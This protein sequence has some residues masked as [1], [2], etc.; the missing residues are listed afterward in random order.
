METDLPWPSWPCQA[1]Q[2]VLRYSTPGGGGGGGGGGGSFSEKLHIKSSADHF[3]NAVNMSAVLNRIMQSSIE[4]EATQ[5][6]FTL[7]ESLKT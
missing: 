1:G 5:T 7:L 6:I 4:N 3:V 2:E